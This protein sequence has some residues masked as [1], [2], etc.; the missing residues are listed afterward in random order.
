M[1]IALLQEER[2]LPS[3]HGSNKSNR[4]L[5]EGLAREGHDCRALCSV[6]PLGMGR[7]DVKYELARRGVDLEE[8]PAGLYSYCYRG[9]DVR[10]MP[11]WA[12]HEERSAFLLSQLKD[13]DPDVVLV[14][15]SG[16][17]YM[18]ATA[19]A[20]APGHTVYLAHSHDDLPFGPLA[21]SIDEQRTHLIRRARAVVTVSHYSQEYFRAHA[22][23]EAVC[24]RFPVYGEGPYPNLGCFD[25]GCVTLIKATASKGV[26]M[27]LDLAAGFPEVQFA[28]LRWRASDAALS[29]MAQFGN[30]QIWGPCDDIQQVLGRTRVLLAPSTVPETFGLIVPEAMLRGIPVI[31]SSLGGLPEAKLGVDA[32][33]PV[34]AGFAG[35]RD[36]LAR[37]LTDRGAY[38]RCSQ[39]SRAA[40]CHF[41]AAIDVR[42]FEELFQSLRSRDSR[43]HSPGLRRVAVVDPFDAGFL[44]AQEVVRRGYTC[45]SVVSSEHI[46]PEIVAKSDPRLFVETIQHRDDV[47]ATVASLRDHRVG[48]VLPG[49]ETGVNLGDELSEAL[50]FCSNRTALSAARRNKFLMAEAARK[51]QVAVPAQFFS[52]R[53]EELVAWVE[54][55]SRW[56]V[57]VKPAQSLASDDVRICR[58]AADIADAFHAVVGRRNIAGVMNDGLIVQELMNAT[59]YVVDTVSY[60][61]EHYLSGIWR[62]GRPEWAPD[63]LRAL[64]GDGP[65]PASAGKLNW[66][67]LRYGAISSVSKQILP[68][69]GEVAGALFDYAARVLDALGIQFG[70]AHLELMWTSQGLRLVEVG[71]RV[72]GAPQTHAMNRICTG[73][74]QVEQTLDI[75]L[76]PARFLS[77][78]RR[79]Y[80]LRWHGMMCRLTPWRAGLLRG[81]R[82]L[83]R[84]ERL[85]SFHGAFAMAKP[86]QRVPGCVGVAILLHPDEDVLQ[87]DCETVRRLEKD[88]LY[89]IEEE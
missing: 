51:H 89:R 85:R 61:G 74:S 83:D 53:P 24:L 31:A 32:L 4:A 59:Q 41:V 3:F 81:F 1:K 17:S 2:Y 87:Q 30:V 21:Q 28:A 37:L 8:N 79:S 19:L 67:S 86:G 73:A 20:F 56:P 12:G 18:L 27:F 14:S 15:S 76:D 5:L 29:R 49:C 13:F 68:G 69:E 25:L 52:G 64:T 82:G 50:D 6:V 26:D 39:D 7:E 48:C 60:R 35:W 77:G 22:G 42:P 57:V 10:G 75:F 9:V 45:V 71:A 80:T 40:A 58:S 78:A 33:V 44:L 47:G 84:V 62:Y 46:D 88:D 54:N 23:I 55:N 16:H 72:H 36:A 11:N 65:W 63:V 43:S 34:D 70:P 66:A 38:E